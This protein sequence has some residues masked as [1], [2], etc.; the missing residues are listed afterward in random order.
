MVVGTGGKDLLEQFLTLFVSIIFVMPSLYIAAHDNK[1]IQAPIDLSRVG[2]LEQS[3]G[4][5]G[6]E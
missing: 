5:I 2:T 3:I 1:I 4:A 6:T